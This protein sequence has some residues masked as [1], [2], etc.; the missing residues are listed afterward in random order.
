MGPMGRHLLRRGQ[1]FGP[2]VTTLKLHLSFRVLA[3]RTVPVRVVLS[4]NG[5]Y[6]PR[7]NIASHPTNRV[8]STTC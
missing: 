4:E 1:D 7:G 6:N 5:Q 2:R 3:G 8:I